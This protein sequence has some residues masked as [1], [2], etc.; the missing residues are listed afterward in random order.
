M[1]KILIVDDE[2]R[3]VDLIELFLNPQGFKCIKVLD[4]KEALHVVRTQ[5]VHL[6]VLD[7]MMPGMDGFEVCAEIR[8]LSTVPIL[9]LT[10]REGKEEVVKGLTLGAD[11]YVTKPF[12]EE[13]LVARVQALLRRV[14]EPAPAGVAADGYRLD[15]ES[16]A[17]TWDS[18]HVQLTMKEYQLVEAMMKHPNRTY[19]REQLLMIA[20]EYD[21][22]TDPRTVDSHIRNLREKLKK[23]GFPTDQFLVTIWGIGYRW[24]NESNKT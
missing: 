18:H 12:D 14:P 17:L 19:T 20:W 22:Y 7:V 15:A 16:Y 6:V 13:E 2:R 10:A 1:K 23:A 8:K 9:M 4:G 11:D 3:M 5:T 24:S 21:S